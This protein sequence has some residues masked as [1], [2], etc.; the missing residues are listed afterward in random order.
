VQLTKT[1]TVEDQVIQSMPDVSPT[2]WHLAHTTWFFETFLLEH[3]PDYRP[4]H[5]QFR[6]LFNSYYQGVGG[7]HPR[8]Q[9]GLVGRP[10][11]R[12]ILRYRAHVDEELLRRLGEG[13]AEISSRLSAIELGLHHEQQHQE[14]LLMDIQHVLSCNPL[15]PAFSTEPRSS[16]E[17]SSPMGW[18]SFE[19]GLVEIGHDGRGFA[20]DNEGPRHRVW[21][22]AGALGSRLVTNGEYLQFMLDGGYDTAQLWLSDAWEHLQRT[23]QWSAPLYWLRRDD[24]WMKFSLRG[25]QPLNLD[26]PVSHVSYYEADAYA[27]WAGLR[28]PT[29]VEWESI[30]V[31][32]PVAGNLLERESWAPS[33]PGP[34]KSNAPQQMYGDLWEWTQSPYSPYPGYRPPAGAIGEYNGKF[35]CNQ[36]VLRGGSFATAQWHLR[37]SYRNF[38]HP[39]TRWHFSG[40]RLARDP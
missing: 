1:L 20:Y 4:F 16:N 5:P 15:F 33:V 13:D 19:E 32:Q 36:F 18:H 14:L 24:Q 21:R 2:K 26:E 7:M 38:F 28:L 35:M 8:P 25:L 10:G 12:E 6:I 17:Q 9:R 22:E 29:E 37:P 3:C 40:I 23:E 34:R 11:V 27:R 30:A 39:W 31:G